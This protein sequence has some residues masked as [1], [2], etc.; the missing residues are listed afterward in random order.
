MRT[1]PEAARRAVAAGL[2][3][4]L[5]L[6]IGGCGADDESEDP[7]AAEAGAVD[8]ATSAPESSAE[9][10]DIP[11]ATTI[12]GEAFD[13]VIVKRTS[14]A[15]K[16]RK[17]ATAKT[18]AAPAR[19]RAGKISC[20]WSRNTV[21]FTATF[22]NRLETPV[23]V[24]VQPIYRLRNA[25]THGRG[26]ES[27]ATV[28]LEAGETRRWVHDVGKPEEIAETKQPPITQCTLRINDAIG[29]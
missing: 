24:W 25:G 29:E 16:L 8:V 10:P 28:L 14:K 18:S 11:G 1:P 21:W 19:L 22:A 26:V 17:T 7:A 4:V 23:T 27:E 13:P 20:F 15:G 12:D 9:E 3:T 2:A 5:L 6:A